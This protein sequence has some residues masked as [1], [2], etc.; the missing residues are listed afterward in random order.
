VLKKGVLA[1]DC[2]TIGSALRHSTHIADSLQRNCLCQ[3]HSS[4]K[5]QLITITLCS[6]GIAPL[7]AYASNT[8]L[9]IYS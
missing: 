4:L 2:L 9:G 8:Q 5:N 1:S 3:Y 6:L 7:E